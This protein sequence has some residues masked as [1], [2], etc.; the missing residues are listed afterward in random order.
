MRDVDP[1]ILALIRNAAFEL[2]TTDPLA[3]VRVLRRLAGA[4]GP[5]EVLARGALGEIY[6]EELGD[7][8]G[9]EHEYR[10]VLA[11]APGLAAAQLGLARVLRESGAEREAQAYYRGA[12]ASLAA[13]VAA[14][15]D[16]AAEG[17]AIPA[18]AEEVVLSLL[19]AA[20]EAADL[21][22]ASAASLATKTSPS[23]SEESGDG[24]RGAH[25]GVAVFDETLLEWAVRERLFDALSEDEGDS[26]DDWVRFHSLRANLLSRTGRPREAAEA[27]A[28]AHAVLQEAM[29]AA[30]A[31]LD[32]APAEE[33]ARLEEE[34]RG[35]REALA[36]GADGLVTLRSRKE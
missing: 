9:A 28:R 13:E 26:I 8:D 27:R 11:L 36:D 18:G 19:E 15:R 31:R 2:R 34:I 30:R 6:F 29:E 23:R 12:I 20:V 22:A 21:G 3:A 7:L 10:K 16:L 14:F 32:A 5:A 17:R 1:E 35:Y 4:G 33:R 25:D 24:V